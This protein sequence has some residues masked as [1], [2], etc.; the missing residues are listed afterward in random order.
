M[1]KRDPVHEA[2]TRLAALKNID[3]PAALAEGL[4]PLLADTGAA[5]VF[6]VT[7]ATVRWWMPELVGRIPDVDDRVER[8]PL[9]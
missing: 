4:A 1:A 8:A 9:E 6:I 7:W 3:E 5:T 2:I